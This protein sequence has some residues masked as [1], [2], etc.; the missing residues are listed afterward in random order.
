MVAVHGMPIKEIVQKLTCALDQMQRKK[1]VLSDPSVLECTE[2]ITTLKRRLCC[3]KETLAETCK[4]DTA[5]EAAQRH[6]TLQ[7]INNRLDRAR[8]CRKK[9][10]VKA[11]AKTIVGSI[12]VHGGRK[13]KCTR[14]LDEGTLISML[15]HLLDRCSTELHGKYNYRIPG[16]VSALWCKAEAIIAHKDGRLRTAEL[17]SKLPRCKNSEL[18]AK[19]FIKKVRWHTF[20]AKTIR[21]PITSCKPRLPAERQ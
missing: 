9:A 6:Y 15:R 2:K 20:K 17:I 8:Q 1:Q 19:P 11:R 13:T 12:S 5:V 4:E 16:R 10:K 21:A 3:L 7:C 14:T 18:Q